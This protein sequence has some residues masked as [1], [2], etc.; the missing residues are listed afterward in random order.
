MVINDEASFT[1]CL[2]ECRIIGA[3][4][5]NQ[6]DEGKMIRNDRII[7]LP[8]NN[9]AYKNIQSIRDLDKSI[10]DEIEHFFYSYHKYDGVKFEPIKTVGPDE[11]VRLIERSSNGNT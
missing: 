1:G 11:A 6:S 9:V 7:A 8:V 2:I 5:A 3:I 10:V 4:E